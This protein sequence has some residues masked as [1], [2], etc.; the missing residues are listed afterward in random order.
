MC[1]RL[2]NNPSQSIFSYVVICLNPAPIVFTRVIVSLLPSWN[3]QY[4]A[5][6]FSDAVILCKGIKAFPVKDL[7]FRLFL[8][9]NIELIKY[10]DLSVLWVIRRPFMRFSIR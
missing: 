9:V 3:S 2:K 10:H 8:R 7:S 1:V 5:C 4:L 6:L